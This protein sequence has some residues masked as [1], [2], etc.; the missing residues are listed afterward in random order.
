MLAGLGVPDVDPDPVAGFDP[1]EVPAEGAADDPAVL[2]FRG[3]VAVQAGDPAAAVQYLTR[4]VEKAPSDLEILYNL[5][6]ALDQ[7]GRPEE[8]KKYRDRRA[9]AEKDLNDLSAITRAIAKDPRNADLRY[10]AGVILLRNGHPDGG[11]RWLQSALAENPAHEP[12]RKA[13]AE[14]KRGPR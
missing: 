4:A 5:A 11:V 8:A 7:A 6:A 3:T 9:A 1:V 12:S 10:Q 13:L 14:A 2:G